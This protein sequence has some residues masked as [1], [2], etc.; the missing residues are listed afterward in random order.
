MEVAS[1]FVM[2][3]LIVI[4]KTI[5]K[6]FLELA[7]QVIR[8]DLRL[9]LILLLILNDSMWLDVF[10]S[11]KRLAQDGSGGHLKKGK[12]SSFPGTGNDAPTDPVTRNP[13]SENAKPMAN[14]EDLSPV[15]VF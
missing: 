6:V 5:F 12:I 11:G 15:F 10:S 9:T 4:E 7:V 1:V 14:A 13:S 8:I 3:I 2:R